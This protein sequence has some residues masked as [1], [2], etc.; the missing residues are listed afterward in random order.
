AAYFAVL[1]RHALSAASRASDEDGGGA[2]GAFAG[3]EDRENAQQPNDHHSG[4]QDRPSGRDQRSVSARWR[5]GDRSFE[6]YRAAGA[7]RCA[8][9]P[10]DESEFRVLDA[11]EF[12]AAAG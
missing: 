4:R 8:H 1:R 9:A 5:Y 10:Y 7:D 11:G 6:R 2:R 12:G 3:R